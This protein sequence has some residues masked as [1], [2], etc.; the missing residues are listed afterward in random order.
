MDWR[1][2]DLL[3]WEYFAGRCKP[4]VYNTFGGNY[5]YEVGIVTWVDRIMEHS[6]WQQT[7]EEYMKG[8]VI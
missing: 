8:R 4:V 5:A 2:L 3:M 6:S 1:S 7:V